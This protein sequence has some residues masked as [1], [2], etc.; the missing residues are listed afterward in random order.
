MRGMSVMRGVLLG[1]SATA[2][3]LGMPALA[4]DQTGGD[5]QAE[6]QARLDALKGR[7]AAIEAKQDQQQQQDAAEYYD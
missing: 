7:L 5:T 6:L 4:D 1:T 3:L 2:A